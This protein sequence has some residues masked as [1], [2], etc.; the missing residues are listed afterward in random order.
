M[1]T[2]KSPRPSSS[3]SLN[4]RY[5]SESV[6]ASESTKQKT[7]LPSQSNYETIRIP[8]IP[9]GEHASVELTVPVLSWI[10]V[11]VVVVFLVFQLRKR[12]DVAR[13]STKSKIRRASREPELELDWID[14]GDVGNGGGGG[15]KGSVKKGS[16][17]KVKKRKGG[18]KDKKEGE[19]V[20]GGGAVVE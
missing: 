8:E 13:S 5:N 10:T 6:R 7:S 2:M 3:S 1:A 17:K 20:G 18:G 15:K 16:P 12:P 14:D 11:L 9:A 19:R 4:S